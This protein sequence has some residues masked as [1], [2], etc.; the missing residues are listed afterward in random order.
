MIKTPPP[1][2]CHILDYIPPKYSYESDAKKWSKQMLQVQLKKQGEHG[3]AFRCYINNVST[4]EFLTLGTSFFDKYKSKMRLDD[5]WERR[6][7]IISY[8]FNKNSAA[9]MIQRAARKYLNAKR[10]S[11]YIR[12]GNIVKEFITTENSYCEMLDVVVTLIYQPLLKQSTRIL[13]S[14]QIK[15]LF[16]NVSVIHGFN[17]ELLS[18]LRENM[19]VYSQQSLFGKL[20]LIIIPFLKV[21][22]DYCQIYGKIQELVGYLKPPHPFSLYYKQQMKK[23]PLHLQRFDILALL[24]TPVQ[25]LPRYRLLLTD[26]VKHM[27]KTHPDYADTKKALDE[28]EKVTAFVN[29]QS[30]KQ[31][32]MEMIMGLEAKLKGLPQDIE[33]L[34]HDRQYINS[35]SLQ[36]YE[37]YVAI[38]Q[39]GK[40]IEELTDEEF[41]RIQQQQIDS[42][43]PLKKKTNIEIEFFEKSITRDLLLFNDIIIFV[44]KTKNFLL[45][46]TMQYC[47]CL[48]I[49]NSSVWIDPADESKIIIDCEGKLHKIMLEDMEKNEEWFALL[50]DTF[51]SH[52]SLMKNLQKRRNTLG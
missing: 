15:L 27:D 32:N 2:L 40:V 33:L 7:K 1:P 21:Y 5:T 3:L 10:E 20:L 25:R 43:N 51:T 13:T 12:C 47:C 18:N 41:K 49:S 9:C 30:R 50:S 19:S 26:L 44:E 17:K 45:A 36:Y 35:T 28:I 16:G 14:D 34:Q 37:Q 23:A 24:I 4:E 11:A 48:K 39:K 52:H 31:K 22:S 42:Q 29:L 6:I 38:K 8:N 46:D